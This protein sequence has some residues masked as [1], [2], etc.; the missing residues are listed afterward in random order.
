MGVEIWRGVADFEDRYQVSNLGRVRCHPSTGYSYQLSVTPPENRPR[1]Y[2]AI[3]LRRNGFRKRRTVHRIVA[4]AFLPPR[5]SM[6]HEVRHLDGNRAN[7]A[8]NNLA[9]GTRKENAEDRE[10]HG[11]T[12]SGPSHGCWKDGRWKALR[13]LST[14]KRIAALKARLP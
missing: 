13:N 11:R 2:A 14:K 5:P 1:E 10:R 9:W 3:S 12:A 4:D 7:C 8:A 6:K